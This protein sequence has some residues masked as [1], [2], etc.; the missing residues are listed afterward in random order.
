[1]I[2]FV[3]LKK[4]YPEPWNCSSVYQFYA[5]KALFRVPKICNINFW[6]ENDPPLELFQKYELRWIVKDKSGQKGENTERQKNI[7]QD[8]EGFHLNFNELRW[9]DMN[10]YE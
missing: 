7:T 10:K 1:M 6:I 9:T 5:E 8:S 2:S 3:E 4:T